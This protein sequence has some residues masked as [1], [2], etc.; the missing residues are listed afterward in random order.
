MT[1][2]HYNL[3]IV[4]LFLIAVALLSVCVP[5]ILV[6]WE[7][8]NRYGQDIDCTHRALTVYEVGVENGW[9]VR[10]MKTTNHVWAEVKVLGVWLTYDVYLSHHKDAESIEYEELR[11]YIT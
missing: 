5:N 9:D 8:E 2:R 1:L 6:D 11:R 10:L 4:A 7:T 3:V